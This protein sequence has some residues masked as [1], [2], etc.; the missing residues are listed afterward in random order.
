MSKIG[1]KLIDIPEN[2]NIEIDKNLLNCINS[3]K[4]KIEGIKGYLEQI[5]PNN[6]IINILNKKLEITISSINKSK[7]YLDKFIK[8]KYGLFRSLI[9][10]MIYGVTQGFSK[11]LIL[12]GIGYKYTLLNNKIILD[13]GFSHKI[14]YDIPKDISI[15]SINPIKLIISGIDKQKVG[16]FASIIKYNRFPE[17]YKGKGIFYE[18]EKIIK[19]IGKKT[20]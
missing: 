14:I 6:I 12:E 7:S 17:P 11:T 8:S 13:I 18:N 4:I 1:K 15:I 20:K 10:N 19:K 16:Q 2:V 9:Y 3:Y 5:I